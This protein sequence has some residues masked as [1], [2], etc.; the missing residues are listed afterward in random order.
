MN[1]SIVFDPAQIEAIEKLEL[2]E[3]QKKMVEKG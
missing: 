2:I 1:D 3:Q